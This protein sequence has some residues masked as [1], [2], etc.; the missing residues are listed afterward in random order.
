MQNERRGLL[1]LLAKSIATA[2]VIT[3]A[4]STATIAK[5]M[6]VYFVLQYYCNTFYDTTVQSLDA[7]LIANNCNTAILTTPRTTDENVQNCVNVPSF[8]QVHHQ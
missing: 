1:A 8:T 6:L 3:G 7:I 4:R 2:M 5:A